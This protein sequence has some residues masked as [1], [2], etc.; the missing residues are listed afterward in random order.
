MDRA[1]PRAGE[2]GERR[3]RDHRQIDGD[4]VALLRPGRLQ[5]I[6]EA[7]D[8]RVKL[9][10]ADPP[11]FRLGVIRLPDDGN[12]V[13]PAFQM[14]VKAV[15][16]DVQHPVLEPFYAE[17]RLVEG[18]VRYLG[19]WL[20]PVDP[21]AV[22]QPEGVGIAKR[23]PIHFRITRRIHLRTRGPFGRNWNH[24]LGTHQSLSRSEEHTSELQSLM[25]L[26][27]AVFCLKKKT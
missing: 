26:S 1:D 12:V 19:E 25:R 7:A 6:G 16:A 2:H 5:H 23:L 10:I 11:R 22:F 24:R 8:L 4:P 15:G 18:P 13:A 17:V 20:D 14:P 21:P 9:A 27:Y 3:L